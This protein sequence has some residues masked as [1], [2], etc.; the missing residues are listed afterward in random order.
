[1][2]ANEQPVA[3]PWLRNGLWVLGSLEQRIMSVIWD[4]PDVTFPDLCDR[5]GPGQSAATVTTVLRRL[6]DKGLLHRSGTRR[7]FRYRPAISQADFHAYV[8]HQ[9]SARLLSQ[10]G[11]DAVA[12][13]VGAAAAVDP[14]LLDEIEAQIKQRKRNDAQQRP[15]L[16]ADQT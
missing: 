9:I 3:L 2:P 13:F 10:V 4:N 12:H 8:S 1:M 11:S 5:L 15:D 7:N 6:M 14:A 16:S